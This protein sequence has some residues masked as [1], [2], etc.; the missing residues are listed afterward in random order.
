MIDRPTDLHMREG[1]RAVVVDPA[2]RVLLVRW[3][4][5]GVS[6]WGTPGG[7]IEADEA[8]DAALHRELAEELGLR[9]AVIGPEI[10]DRFHV[11]PILDKRYDGQHDRFFLVETAAFEPAPVLTR[12]QLEAENLFA[13][14]WWTL[15]ELDAFEST[16]LEFFA[17]RRLPEFVR[18]LLCNGLPASPI[19]TGQ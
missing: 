1:V 6:V 3:D 9:D 5:H 2:Q 14:R 13:I 4:L 19:D 15:D 17:P 18:S 16:E 11:I 12:E 7:G 10:W 8:V